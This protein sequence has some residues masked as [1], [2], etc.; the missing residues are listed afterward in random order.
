MY[1]A[2]TRARKELHVS[3]CVKRRRAKEWQTCAPSRFIAEMGTEA[4]QIA[5]TKRDTNDRTEGSTSIAAL[6]AMLQQ[7]EKTPG[8]A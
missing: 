4:V 2:V 5:G 1:V 6:R 7:P 3:H 8:S